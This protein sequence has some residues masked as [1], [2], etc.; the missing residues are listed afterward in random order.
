MKSWKTAPDRDREVKDWPKEENRTSESNFGS[1]SR[2]REQ[3]LEDSCGSV[4]FGRAC[5]REE[6][7]KC[8]LAVREEVGRMRR[9]HAKRCRKRNS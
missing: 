3:E 8:K 7:N 2:E 1:R 6:T 4:R 9:L 5:P